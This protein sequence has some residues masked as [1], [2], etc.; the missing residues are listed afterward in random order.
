MDEHEALQRLSDDLSTPLPA[1]FHASN[2]T[3]DPSSPTLR[4]GSASRPALVVSSTS[5]TADEDFTPLITALDAYQLAYSSRSNLPKLL[6][7]ITGKGALRSQFE[8][9][10]AARER[11][12]WKDVCVRCAFVPSRDYP[13]ILGSADL[14]I[15]VHS[16]SS[17]LDLPMKIVDMFGCGTPVLARGFR[18]VGELVQDGVNGRV[19]TTAGE[20]GEQLIVSLSPFL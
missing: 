18:A 8:N 5:W 4:K 16:S 2:F 3:P 15:S 20:L 6:V 17:G 14:G 19:W 12:T 9:I 13:L 10:V 11:T 7:I 1:P